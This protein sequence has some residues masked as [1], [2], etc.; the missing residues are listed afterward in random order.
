MEIYQ[1]N[2]LSCKISYCSTVY[3]QLLCS[4]PAK[5][6]CI[7][8]SPLCISFALQCIHQCSLYTLAHN[9][10]I[11]ACNRFPCICLY[12]GPVTFLLTK[13]FVCIFVYRWHSEECDLCMKIWDLI[14]THLFI[15]IIYY[16]ISGE[17]WGKINIVF[18]TE[19]S[20]PEV[21]PEDSKKIY[22]VPLNVIIRK[23]VVATLEIDGV[24]VTREKHGQIASA[25]F[26]VESVDIDVYRKING[27]VDQWKED[28]GILCQWRHTIGSGDLK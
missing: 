2:F 9:I 4:N 25:P 24:R 27:S 11:H 14:I 8:F 21:I 19:S 10:V 26:T 3:Y 13:M 6:A 23:H 18:D 17:S 12:F 22:S 16:P 5:F 7:T 20:P 28:G 1:N 15:I